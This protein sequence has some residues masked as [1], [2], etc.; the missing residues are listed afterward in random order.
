MKIKGWSGFP[1][2]EA[3]FFLP[4]TINQIQEKIKNENNLIARGNGRS[5]GDSSISRENTISMLKFN[6]IIS[7]NDK[8]GELIAESGIILKD[9]I[10]KY[11]PLGWFPYV[12][13]GSKQVTLGGMISANV[14]GKNHH[15]DG[16]FSKYI[17]WIDLICSDGNI[18]RCSKSENQDL[19][20]WTI[21]GMGLTG[22]IIKASIKLKKIETSWIKKKTLVAKNLDEAIDIFEK[23]MHYT[24][25]VAWIDSLKKGSSAGRSIIFLGEHARIKDLERTN[26]KPFPELNN[27]LK[28]SI[29]FYFPNWFL[30]KFLVKI[31]NSLFFFINKKKNTEVL[32][33]WNNFFYP[34]D[35]IEDWYKIYGKKGFVQY[36]CVIPIDK[37][38]EGLKELLKSISKSNTG[39][40]LSVLKRFGEDQ[41]NI[42]FPLE[43]YTLALDFPLNKKNLNLF[44]EL[45]MIT[46][47]YGGRFYLAKDSR[48]SSDI[49]LKSDS[50]IDDF[51]SFRKKNKI[52]KKFTSEQSTRLKI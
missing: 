42:S 39:S 9:L 31:F 11:L 43:G 14:H 50:R 18:K 15:K 35:S 22:I 21:G 26:L 16:S 45:D 2:W 10:D 6:K 12:T 19:F 33:D 5:Y 49:Y 4:E 40:F 27:K 48:I 17:N 47:K 24:Y 36:Q 23:N 32:E 13:P 29:P 1:E 3:K 28:K 7:F 30:N 52:L 41:T 25:T 34:L 20:N 51:I 44:S 8:S 38:R 37:S 46:L